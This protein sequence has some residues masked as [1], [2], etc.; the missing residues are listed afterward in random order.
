MTN[1]ILKSYDE[2]LR[3]SLV[4][5]KHISDKYDF[6]D[7]K[8]EQV[9]KLAENICKLT[10][11]AKVQMAEFYKKKTDFCHIDRIKGEIRFIRPYIIAQ[12]IRLQNNIKYDDILPPDFFVKNKTLYMVNTIAFNVPY[13]SNSRRGILT[14]FERVLYALSIF[15]SLELENLVLLKSKDYEFS[16]E[17]IKFIEELNKNFE[18]EVISIKDLGL[19]EKDF[20]NCIFDLIES[21]KPEWKSG[22]IKNMEHTSINLKE[23]I[24]VF[25]HLIL[26]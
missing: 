24:N 17:C 16:P 20:D 21:I 9:S 25:G 8:S 7:I 2:N 1:T 15:E 26:G 3:H 6:S 18:N 22:R 12:V 11:K 4:G 14:D 19:S 10:I 5:H 13:G 23:K